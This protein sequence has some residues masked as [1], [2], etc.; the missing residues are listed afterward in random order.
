VPGGPP[1]ANLGIQ[2]LVLGAQ[3]RK[4]ALRLVQGCELRVSGTLD[5]RECTNTNGERRWGLQLLAQEIAV[6]QTP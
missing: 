6:K 1:P 3:A 2:A 5:A 4:L